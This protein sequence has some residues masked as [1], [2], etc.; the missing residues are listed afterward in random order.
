MGRGAPRNHKPGGRRSAES[1]NSYFLL[2]QE[3]MRD[4]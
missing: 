1:N 3:L 4:T 2:G